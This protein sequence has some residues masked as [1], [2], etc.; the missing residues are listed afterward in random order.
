MKDRRE[1]VQKLSDKYDVNLNGADLRLLWIIPCP[2][3]TYDISP[4]IY[5]WVLKYK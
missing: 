2:V 5:R 1:I 4:V 3:G